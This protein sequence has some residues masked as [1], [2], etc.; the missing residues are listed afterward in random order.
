MLMQVRA[1]L[2][3]A[4]DSKTLAIGA[5]L[6]RHS[7]RPCHRAADERD[8]LASLHGPKHDFAVV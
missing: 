6:C 5:L 3:W 8:E 4:E 2:C 7:E 1:W